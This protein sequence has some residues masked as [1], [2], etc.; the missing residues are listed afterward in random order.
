MHV[1]AIHRHLEVAHGPDLPLC[2]MFYWFIIGHC[3]SLSSLSGIREGM[4]GV[5]QQGQC[6]GCNSAQSP[7]GPRSPTDGLHLFGQGQIFG[8]L[9]FLPAVG[10]GCPQGEVQQLKAA[11]RA[12]HR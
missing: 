12:G 7:K 3:A 4:E 11:L 9:I 10:P 1:F 5:K 6:M 2:L 8:T